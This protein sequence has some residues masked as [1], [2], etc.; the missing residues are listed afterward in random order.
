MAEAVAGDQ[1][2]RFDHG[3]EHLLTILSAPSGQRFGTCS[4]GRWCSPVGHYTSDHIAGVH[5]GHTAAPG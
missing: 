2:G 1:P 4:C 5:R 3:R